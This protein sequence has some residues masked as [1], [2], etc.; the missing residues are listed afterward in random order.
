MVLARWWWEVYLKRRDGKFRE[1]YPEGHAEGRAETHKEW[2]EWNRRR[3]A[4]EPFN[5]PPPSLNRDGD[6]P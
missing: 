2:V 4:G 5:E 1:G 6:T 3:E